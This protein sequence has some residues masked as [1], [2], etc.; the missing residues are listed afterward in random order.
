MDLDLLSYD[1]V[2]VAIERKHYGEARGICEDMLEAM[3]DNPQVFAMLADIHHCKGEWLEAVKFYDKAI[4][5]DQRQGVWWWALSKSHFYLHNYTGCL[6]CGDIAQQLDVVDVDGLV[7]MAIAAANISQDDCSQRS[8]ALI[9]RALAH[10]WT[11]PRAHMAMGELLLHRREY[12]PGWREYAWRKKVFTGIDPRP[13]SAEWAG[14][15]LRNGTLIVMTEGGFGDCIQFSRFIPYVNEQCSDVVIAS[16]PEITKMF[17]RAFPKNRV[18]S[19]FRE[20][21]PHAMHVGMIDLPMIYGTKLLPPPTD[22][23]VEDRRVKARRDMFFYTEPADCLKVGICWHGRKEHRADARR[24]MQVRQILRLLASPKCA[25]YS[26][27]LDQT[28][29]ET[30][31]LGAD[32]KLL[33]GVRGWQDTAEHILNLD[34]VITVDT[35]VGHLAATLGKPTW[36]ML[37]KPSEWRWGMQGLHSEWYPTARL[38]RQPTPGDWESVIRD[39]SEALTR[40]ASIP[41]A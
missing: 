34:L 31:A 41:A 9:L 13:C 4:A 6:V 11:N 21:P 32:V 3:G 23:K 30:A 17:V 19:Q 39:V 38:W 37:A 40:M 22:F 24:S 1:K 36:I 10:D 18:I 8:E 27:Q 5:I 15:R 7:N 33:T 25:F 35:A 14:Q 20:F 2:S 26:L 16:C 12:E 28:E 29:E